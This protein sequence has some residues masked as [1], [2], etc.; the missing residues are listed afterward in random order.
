MTHGNMTY[1]VE[2]RLAD[3]SR[4]SA[5]RHG[6][7]RTDG[8]QGRNEKSDNLHGENSIEKQNEKI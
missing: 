8:G 1:L 6:G 2:Q 3:L 7:E 4:G 5:R